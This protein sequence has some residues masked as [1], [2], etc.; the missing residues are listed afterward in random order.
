MFYSI[1]QPVQDGIFNY[2]A[3][4]GCATESGQ[5]PDG[6]EFD[7]CVVGADRGIEPFKVEDAVVSDVVNIVRQCG[8][9]LGGVEYFVTAE[10]STPCYYDFNPYSNFVADGSSL[11]GFSP[12]HRYIDFVMRCVESRPQVA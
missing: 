4:D 6:T 9:D 12:E 11:L 10:S 7:F 2:C 8:A 1:R 5:Q 3:A